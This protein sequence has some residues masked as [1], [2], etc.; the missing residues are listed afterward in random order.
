MTALNGAWSVLSDQ[1]KRAA[2]DR[3]RRLRNGNDRWD[4]Y[5]TPASTATHSVGTVLEFGR[6]AGWSIPEVTRRDPDYLEWLIRTP[7]GRRYRSE[8]EAA[9]PSSA[10][11]TAPV[12]SRPAQRSRWRR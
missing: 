2:Y 11:A 12:P 6:Y 7:N 10:V 4:A 8:I 1:T 9:V 5:L 3:E